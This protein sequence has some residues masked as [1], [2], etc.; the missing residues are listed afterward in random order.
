MVCFTTPEE[1]R[2]YHRR[3]LETPKGFASRKRIIVERAVSHRR[4]PSQKT[5]QKY[6]IE[7]EDLERIITSVRTHAS[8]ETGK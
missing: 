1:R 5:L 8:A 7:G 6:C 3:W 4:C 2:E